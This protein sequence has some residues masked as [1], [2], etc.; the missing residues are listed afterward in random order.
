MALAS[1]VFSLL[2]Q[3]PIVL[4]ANRTMKFLH[5]IIQNF[6]LLHQLLSTKYLQISLLIS[7]SDGTGPQRF[8]KFI[9]VTLTGQVKKQVL[10]ENQLD[11]LT[12][13]MDSWPWIKSGLTRPALLLTK[14]DHLVEPILRPRNR[15]PCPP[16]LLL[17]WHQAW[18]DGLVGLGGWGCCL[19]WLFFLLLPLIIELITVVAV[20]KSA[21]I[22]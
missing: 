11:L 12:W 21:P 2:N 5:K 22:L 7:M 6:S 18:N 9:S 17:R 19:L 8:T 13:L 1:V 4:D 3:K 10:T 16:I 20:T 15:V 14:L